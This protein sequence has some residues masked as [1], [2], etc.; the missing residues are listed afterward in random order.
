MMRAAATM[1]LLALALAGCADTDPYERPGVWRPNG[2]NDANLRAMVA[3]PSDLVQGV[4][5][6]PGDG[7]QAALALDRA[8]RDRVRPLPDSAIAKVLPVATG[9]AAGAP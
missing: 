9:N 2:A 3:V 5:D 4:P 6:A 8:R 7:Q 1:L